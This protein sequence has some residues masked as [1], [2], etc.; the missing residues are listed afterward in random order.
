MAITTS[1]LGVASIAALAGCALPSTAWSGEP[2]FS[3]AAGAEYSTGEYGGTT[4]GL[5]RRQASYTM[6]CVEADHCGIR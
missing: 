6:R 3:M 2:V 5:A 1:R 4:G